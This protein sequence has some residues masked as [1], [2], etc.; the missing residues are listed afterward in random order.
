MVGEKEVFVAAGRAIFQ[1]GILHID[2]NSGDADTV[3]KDNDFDFRIIIA[4]KV[5][6]A[7]GLNTSHSLSPKASIDRFLPTGQQ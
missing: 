5:F 3:M 1:N 2:G 7:Y 4:S 6:N